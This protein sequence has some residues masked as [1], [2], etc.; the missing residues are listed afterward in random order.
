[1]IKVTLSDGQV[2][3]VGSVV[4]LEVKEQSSLFQAYMVCISTSFLLDIYPHDRSYQDVGQSYEDVIRKSLIK[5]RNVLFIAGKEAERSIEKP[6][7]QYCETGW[8]FFVEDGE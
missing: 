4:E 1:M 6:I 5:A 7:F 2:Y 8:G 3:F